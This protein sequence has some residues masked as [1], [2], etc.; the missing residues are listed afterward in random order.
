MVNGE[1][2]RN[3]SSL[4]KS[5]WTYVGVVREGPKF[6]ILVMPEGIPSG[7]G[8]YRVLAPATNCCYVGEGKQLNWRLK[9]YQNAK[10]E[11]GAPRAWTDRTV[12]GWIAEGLESKESEFEVWC[13]IEASIKRPEADWVP[14]DLNQKYFRTLIESITIAREPNL[15][16][17]N[18]QYENPEN[19][20]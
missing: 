12:Q 7:P 19:T 9:K 1:F 13:C 17:I 2:K 16:Y 20:K 10:Y 11:R 18:K 14:L 8:I 4:V 5:V 15:K 3:F 6:P